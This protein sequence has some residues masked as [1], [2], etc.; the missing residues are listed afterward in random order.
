MM[1][2]FVNDR[3]AASVLMVI[4]VKLYPPGRVNIALAQT[5]HAEHYEIS[6]QIVKALTV[7]DFADIFQKTCWLDY[8]SLCWTGGLIGWRKGEDV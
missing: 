8:L 7:S 6:Q 2:V 3:I 1:L 5:F 4:G